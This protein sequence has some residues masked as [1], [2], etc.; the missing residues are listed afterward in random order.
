M[1]EY[2]IAIVI[3]LFLVIIAAL[4]WFGI[5]IAFAWIAGGLWF[6]LNSQSRGIG[7]DSAFVFTWPVHL[8]LEG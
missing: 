4:H 6:T 8:W 2:H 1:T 5:L 3:A 7:A